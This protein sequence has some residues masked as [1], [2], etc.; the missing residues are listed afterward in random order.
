M[1]ER[2][3]TARTAL[4]A[5]AA[6]GLG[7]AFAFAFAFAP[8]F[9][10]AA[11]LKSGVVCTMVPRSLQPADKGDKGVLFGKRQGIETQP[12]LGGFAVMPFD[13]L[14]DAYGPPVMQQSRD[15]RVEAEVPQR[16]RAPF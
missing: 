16:R 2:S 1:M 8:S 4:A 10:S 13:G 3:T 14:G 12:D 11:S 5:W 15:S 7:A 9:T 6:F